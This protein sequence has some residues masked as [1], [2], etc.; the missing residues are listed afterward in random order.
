MDVEERL[1][2]T[3]LGHAVCDQA[4]ERGVDR[5]ECDAWIRLALARDIGPRRARVAVDAAGSAAA[6][7]AHGDGWWRE[8][9]FSRFPEVCARVREARAI[10]LDRVRETAAKHG[11]R[12]LAHPELPVSLRALDDAPAALWLRGVLPPPEQPSVAVVGSRAATAYGRLQA[13]RFAGE[14][15]ELG[16]VIVS[17]GARGIDAEAHRAALRANGITV[18]VLGGGFGHLYPPEHAGLFDAIVEGGGAV[19]TEFPCGVVPR[20]ENFPRRNRLVSALSLVVLVVEAAERSGALLTARLAV[21]DQAREVACIPGPV[22]STR[23]AGCH[24]AIREGWAQLAHEPRDVAELI[25]SQRSLAIANLSRAGGRSSS[26]IE[27]SERLPQRVMCQASRGATATST[28]TSPALA[29]QPAMSEE[30]RTVHARLREKPWCG[31]DLAEAL[32]RPWA[33]VAVLLTLLARKGLARLE[34]DEWVAAAPP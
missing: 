33:S 32:D 13:A 4:D 14:L 19:A 6:A 16:V 29:T 24:R 11:A 7:M 21:E 8:L 10:D 31:E 15:A 34:G 9:F 30:E 5:E 18:A 3:K 1:E 28:S 20:P 23:S 25:V 27:R 26:V 12:V 22:D 17:G 2:L